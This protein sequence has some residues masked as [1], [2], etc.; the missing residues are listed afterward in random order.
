[1][2]GKTAKKVRRSR[3]WLTRGSALSNAVQ[4]RFGVQILNVGP[5]TLATDKTSLRC[6]HVRFCRPAQIDVG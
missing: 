5:K 4:A 1:M 2:L 6:S 3:A